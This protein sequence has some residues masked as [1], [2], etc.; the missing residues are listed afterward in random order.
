[1]IKKY[2]KIKNSFFEWSRLKGVNV[3]FEH[4]IIVLCF[5]CHLPRKPFQIPLIW[6][7]YITCLG[8]I[9][10]EIL[11]IDP[12]RST[13]F[14]QSSVTRIS[15][16]GRPKNL[17]F[18]ENFF[19]GIQQP[20]QKSFKSVMVMSGDRVDLTGNETRLLLNSRAITKTRIITHIILY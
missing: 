6:Y 5:L 14:G 1:M 10:A 18:G 12:Y 19:H 4:F 20:H 11:P 17:T 9:G 8:P 15:D 13:H 16:P 2:K 7:I 3:I